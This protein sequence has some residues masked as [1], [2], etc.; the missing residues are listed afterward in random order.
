VR[1]GRDR[2]PE[3]LIARIHAAA[4]DSRVGV[5]DQVE[6][7]IPRSDPIDLVAGALNVA[8]QRYLQ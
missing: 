2:P 6:R 5:G 8:V 1:V 4:E 3:L 7:V